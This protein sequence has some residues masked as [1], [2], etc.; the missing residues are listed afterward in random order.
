VGHARPKKVGLANW[1]YTEI[2]EGLQEKE[3]VVTS[4]QRE[5]VKPGAKVTIGNNTP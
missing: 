4:V 1:E 3:Q 5:G 2:L